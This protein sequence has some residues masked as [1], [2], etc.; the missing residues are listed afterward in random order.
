MSPPAVS[1][2]E[3]PTRDTR[4][5]E[6]RMELERGLRGVQLGV[7]AI[8]GIALPAL[9]TLEGARTDFFLLAASLCFVIALPLAIIRAYMSQAFFLVL[10]VH[11]DANHNPSKGL[12][13][14]LGELSVAFAEIGIVAIAFHISCLHGGIA[15]I[16][17]LLIRPVLVAYT[18]TLRKQ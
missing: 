2:P 6:L 3:T 12:P 8:C 5:L 18:K 10:F 11:G 7:A 13:F 4:Q 16:A 9:I 17:A 14:C 1:S 15:L